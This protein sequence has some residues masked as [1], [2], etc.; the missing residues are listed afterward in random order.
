MFWNDTKQTIINMILTS[1]NF[2]ILSLFY[3]FYNKIN[4]KYIIYLSVEK[5]NT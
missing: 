1:N 2:A 5:K 3:I 4:K